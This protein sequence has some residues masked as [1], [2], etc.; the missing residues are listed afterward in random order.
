MH[1]QVEFF[2]S[3]TRV[4]VCGVLLVGISPAAQR[5]DADQV[6]QTES[7]FHQAFVTADTKELEALL[8]SEFVWMHGTGEVATKEQLIESFRTGRSSY[9]RDD[10]DSV[11]VT[12][13]GEAAVVVGHNV[14]Q[15]G[16]GEVLE[17]RYTTT[18]VKQDG[19]WR[20]AVF[21]SSHCPCK[22]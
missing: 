4:M 20:I 6:R 14:R 5:T 18:Y 2:T 13:Y 3:L 11:N 19:S 7:K 15:L 8:T 10:I 21:H 16:S 22:Q 1:Q 12:L 17:F 9:R